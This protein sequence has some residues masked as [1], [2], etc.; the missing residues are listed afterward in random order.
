M[1]WLKYNGIP[2]VRVCGP[3]SR[4]LDFVVWCNCVARQCDC[5]CLIRRNR[6]RRLELGMP[7]S[8]N[9]YLMCM[10]SRQRDSMTPNKGTAV[11]EKESLAL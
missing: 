9:G 11:F 6:T 3:D 1:A 8:S 4:L 2:L 5:E 10:A 7:S